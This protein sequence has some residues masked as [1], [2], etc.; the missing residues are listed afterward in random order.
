MEH[1]KITQSEIG[2]CTVT[3]QLSASSGLGEWF[4][5]TVYGPQDDQAELQTANNISNRNSEK[6]WSAN[7]YQLL[8]CQEEAAILQ[9]PVVYFMLNLENQPNQILSWELSNTM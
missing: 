3:A 9:Q 5:T 6:T 7:F 1:S 4:V 2:V 8:T